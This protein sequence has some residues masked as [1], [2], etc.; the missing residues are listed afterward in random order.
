MINQFPHIIILGANGFLGRN[1]CYHLK[2]ENI[3]FD[4]IS[5]EPESKSII[6][7]KYWKNFIYNK[8]REDL[9][10]SICVINCI[11]ITD[12]IFCEKNK[13][14][15]DEI[16]VKFPK[17]LSE[18][19]KENNISLF[20]ISTD[21]LFGG[22]KKK[23]ILWTKDQMVNPIS[24]Y[25]K[26]KYESEEVLRKI[27]WGISIRL[28]FVGEGRGSSRGLISFLARA[29]ADEKNSVEG[30]TDIYFNPI[31]LIDF[32]ESLKNL[33]I[34]N[35]TGFN[36][37]QY[38]VDEVLSKYE[39]LKQV[40]SEYNLE[41]IPIK[42]K[43]RLSTLPITYWQGIKSDIKFLKSDMIEKSITSLSNEIRYLKTLNA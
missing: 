1:L 5:R 6:D 13:D 30:Y 2:K 40:S 42:A 21:S 8:R 22:Y 27:N 4:A 43:D 37:L 24:S 36:L 35:K 18:L 31:H 12:L 20:H 14:I 33:I 41:I 26:S 25:S 10:K 17:N 19:C 32:W 7:F 9:I 3:R 16:N 28:S 34:I 15:V 38:G 39:F 23:N 11:A 29:I